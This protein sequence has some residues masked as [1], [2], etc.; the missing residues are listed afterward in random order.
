V[1]KVR[2]FNM[3]YKPVVVSSSGSIV[4]GRSYGEADDSDPALTSA[5]AKGRVVLQS[6]P[7]QPEAEKPKVE[8]A[9]EPPRQEET[10]VVAEAE[11]EETVAEA[12][13][14]ADDGEPEG[15]EP[16][17]QEE[18]RTKRPSRSKAAKEN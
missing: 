4:K 7:Q 8:A 2:V 5:L 9:P 16:E 14:E 12:P 17:A 11:A 18:N 1:A 13:A 10:P 15:D 3:T 6:N